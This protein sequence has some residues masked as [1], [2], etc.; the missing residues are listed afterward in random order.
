MIMKVGG[1]F[2]KI[3]QALDDAGLLERALYVEYGTM[4]GERILP[5][6][7]I[8]HPAPDA[9]YFSMILVPGRQGMR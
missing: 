7:Q 2:P 5:L 8:E 3:L 4:P 6:R 1:N 9:P